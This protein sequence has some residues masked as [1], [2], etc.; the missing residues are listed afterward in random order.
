MTHI[1]HISQGVQNQNILDEFKLDILS[2]LSR[3]NKQISSKYL[4]DDHG[5][6]LFNRITTHPD[7]Y[8]TRCELDILNHA[9]YKIINLLG[10]KP[11]NLVE[12]GPGEGIKTD[13]LI[14]HCLQ[15]KMN[16]TYI[17]VDISYQYLQKIVDKL[18]QR[19]PAI[20]LLPIHSDYFNG[21]KWINLDS[22][23]RNIALF[24]G[25]SIGNFTMLEAEEFLCHLRESL[26][27]YDYAIIG[28]DLR[29][30][31]NMLLRAYNDSD[32]ITRDFNLNLLYRINSVLGANF[33]VSKFTHYETY[34]IVEGAMESYLMN[35]EPQ[36]VTINALN[37][38][39]NFEMSEA[40]HVEYSYKYTMAQ[41][42]D[43]AQRSGFKIVDNYFDSQC[44]FVDS[45]WQSQ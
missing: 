34:N 29:K 1:Q 7:Y 36:V 3:K 42:E 17:P 9:K 26:H 4:Y 30:D 11:F 27:Q 45:L 2:G 19:W 12:L 16:F 22:N 21:L 23:V 38:S 40:I 20:K 35:T 18:D 44:Y 14:D 31:I 39:F 43:L 24:L 28:F 5:S 6:E 15:N 10:D 37:T 13:I 25:S 8:L 33:D 41:I 32:G